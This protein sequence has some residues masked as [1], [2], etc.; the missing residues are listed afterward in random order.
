MPADAATVHDDNQSTDTKPLAR[1]FFE[2]DVVAC[3]RQLVGCR[4]LWG[5]CAGVIVE[6]EAY[7]E[8]GDEACHT[9]SRPSA[10]TF[11]REHHAGA[12][13]VY[14]NYGMHW[15]LNVLTKSPKAGNGLILIRALR[16]TA[17]LDVMRERRAARMKSVPPEHDRWLCSGPGKLAA[18]IAV[19]G[20]D[21]GRNLISPIGPMI[22]PADARRDARLVVEA[23]P[24]I[25]ISKARDLPWR[26]VA[27][28]NAYVSR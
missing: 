21:H 24:R 27:A 28:R 26:F 22:A 9:A 20:A 2:R 8:H 23:T 17:G 1:G 5:G 13:Y 14:F 25:G 11:I 7:A 15:M 10:R 16:P 4:L 18:A 19:T 3:A 6:T 12:A